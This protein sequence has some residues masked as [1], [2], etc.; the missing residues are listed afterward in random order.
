MMKVAVLAALV[1]SAAAFAPSQQARTSTSLAVTEAQRDFFGI[2]SV[3][4]S[5]ELGVQAPLG[6]FDPLGLLKD[7]S[8]ESFND[9]R[10]KEIKHGRVSMLA[11]VGYLVTAAGVRFPG[12]E[13]IPDGLAAWQALLDSKDG[14][15]V[16][17]QMLAFMVVA[18]IC[19]RE[20]FWVEGVKAEFPGDYRNGALD[21]GWDKLSDDMKMKKRAIELNNGRAAMMGIWGLVTH[22]IMGV[23]IL[24]GG[25]LPGH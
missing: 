1:G 2:T 5:T 16:L 22:E 11:V 13:D 7:G 15:N 21:F 18:E 24:P 6:L 12:A 23:S 25:Y 4:F 19:N 20:A 8:V 3:D 17:Y 9:L 10:E 14:N